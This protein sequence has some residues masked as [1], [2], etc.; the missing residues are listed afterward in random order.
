M[1]QRK[2]SEPYTNIIPKTEVVDSCGLPEFAIRCDEAFSLDLQPREMTVD[3]L[4]SLASM[5]DSALAGEPR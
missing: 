5:A 1:P 4:G 2:V 3:T